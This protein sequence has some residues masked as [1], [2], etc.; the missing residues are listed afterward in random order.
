MD[1]TGLQDL[2]GAEPQ[3]ALLLEAAIAWGVAS[4]RRAQPA[5][6]AEVRKRRWQMDA[7]TAA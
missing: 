2:A 7:A 1:H 3:G 6:E 5:D 4:G